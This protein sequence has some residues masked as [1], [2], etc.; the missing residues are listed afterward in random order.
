LIKAAEKEGNFAVASKLALKLGDKQRAL[1]FYNKYARRD[2][3]SEGDYNHLSTS[4]RL[5]IL[6]NKVDREIKKTI[7]K[8]ALAEEQGRFLR[9]E[10][11]RQRKLR[12]KR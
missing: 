6:Q 12:R 11:L 10:K 1:D 3:N 9:A 2:M 5:R 7:G 4:L 8:I